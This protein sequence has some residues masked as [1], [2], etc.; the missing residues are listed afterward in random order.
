[1]SVLGDLELLAQQA[2]LAADR[3]VLHLHV[4]VEGDEAAVASS[5]SG[6]ISGQRHV[7]VAEEAGEG[8]E[9]RGRAVQL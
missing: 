4:G 9:D 3:L 2:F 1:V 7:V 5:A 6:L 8:G